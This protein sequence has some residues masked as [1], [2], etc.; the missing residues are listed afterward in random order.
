MSVGRHD[1]IVAAILAQIGTVDLALMRHRA[2]A[3]AHEDI[4]QDVT[5]RTWSAARHG[6]VLWRD[7]RM[8]RAFLRVVTARAVYAWREQNPQCAELRPHEAAVPSAEGLVMA[9]RT[10][11]FLRTSTTPERWRAVR[12]YAC[13]VPASAIA[14]REHVPTATVYDRMRRARLDFDAALRREDASIY[15]RRKYHRRSG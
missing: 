12:A 9:R 15:V 7:P 11:R 14:D 2:P 10:L 4:R 3:S 1:E 8:L 5:F 13:G 6:R